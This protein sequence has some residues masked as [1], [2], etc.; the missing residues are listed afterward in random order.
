[1]KNKPL[2]SGV[3]K[4]DDFPTPSA[5]LLGQCQQHA[6]PHQQAAKHP[7]DPVAQW[8]PSLTQ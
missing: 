7:V 2:Q 1:M 6:E 8:L 5:R 3:D 4:G